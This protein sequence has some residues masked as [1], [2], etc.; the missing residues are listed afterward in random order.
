MRI[1]AARVAASV[2]VGLVLAP[3]A[4]D[5][6]AQASAPLRL[7]R[8]QEIAPFRLTGI[9]GYMVARYLSDDSRSSGQAGGAGSRARQ[10]NLSEE[11]FLMTHSYIYHPSLLSLDLGGGPVIDKGSYNADGVTTNSKRQLYNLSARATVLR[12]KPYTGA[13]FYDR[14]NQTQSMG[15]AQVMLTENTRYGANFSLLRP[16]TPI[17]MQVELTRSENQGRGAEQVIEDRIDQLRL[18]MD[19]NVG[20][21]GRSAFQYQGTRQDSRSGSSGLPIQASSSSNDGM[22]LDTRLKFGARNE[23]DLSNMVTL[24]TSRYSVGQ[25]ALVRL[26]DFGF[27]LDLR[28]RQSDDL[29]TYGRY[30]FNTSKQDVQETTANSASAGLSYRLTPELSGTLAARGDNTQTSQLSSTL[31]GIDGSAQYRR[32]LPLGEATAGYSFAYSQREQQATALQAN[33][34]GER[35]TLTGTTLV[36]LLQEQI[37]AGTVIVGN[38]TRTQIFVEGLDYV[39]STL[40]LRLRIQRVLGGNILDGQEVLADYAYATGGTY[41]TSQLDNTINLSWALKSYLGVFLRYADSAR[42]LESGLP[43]SPLNPGR[44]ILY[45]SRVELPLSLPWQEFVIGG[46]AEREDRREVIS[47]YERASLEA[48][49]Q[50]ELPFVRN[51]NIR[52][53]RRQMQVDYEYNPAQGVKLAAYDLRLW[54]RVGYGIDLSAEASR[55]RD[56]G[57]PVARERSSASVKAQWRKRKLLLT[58][59]LTRVRDAQGAAE[60]TRTYGQIILR[61]DF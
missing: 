43:T 42:K 27:G 15:P 51:G 55:E 4:G 18:K 22:N 25:G 34:I 59:D 52:I 29:Q 36:P 53:G 56:T 57:T 39:L 35:V 17:P 7:K 32:T 33:V 21:L 9:D 20:K 23:Y 10:S 16:V 12:D 31:Y 38:L 45:G 6:W 44:S 13:L 28:G 40:G 60:R 48:Y 46:R 8:A 54:S 26:Q 37:A 2:A 19:A 41:A 5:C 61:R 3:G 14:S 24:N 50:T 47:P 1:K 49:A 58:F 11:L 30:N